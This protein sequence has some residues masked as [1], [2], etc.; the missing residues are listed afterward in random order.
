MALN[1]LTSLLSGALARK[2]LGKQ[3]Q[4]YE[5]VKNTEEI[6]KGFL[7]TAE[8]GDIKAISYKG[9]VVTVACR[10][11]IARHMFM[12]LIE[13]IETKMREEGITARLSPQIRPD[14]WRDEGYTGGV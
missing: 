9:G 4:A 11:P 14:V 2:G 10:H 12:G 13:P 5:I 7:G 8:Q 6:L 3:L 1:N